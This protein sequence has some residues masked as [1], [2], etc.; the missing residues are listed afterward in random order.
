[1]LQIKDHVLLPFA[2]TLSDVDESLA[3]RLTPEVIQGIVELI[4]DSWLED[5]A[6]FVSIAEHRAAYVT[7]LL[8]RLESPRA[9]VEEAINARSRAV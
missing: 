7:Y 8:S 4:P 6:D 1:M 3:A 9:F 2:A 5:E